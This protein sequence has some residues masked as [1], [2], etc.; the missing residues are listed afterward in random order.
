MSD[1][2]RGRS[3]LVSGGGGGMGRGSALALGRE[4]AKVVVADVNADAAEAV[5]REVTD[6]GGQASALALDVTD[7]S[8]CERAVESTLRTYGGVDILVNFAGISPKS[9]V[10]TGPDDVWHR[11][12]AINLTGTFYLTRA[13]ARPMVERKQGTMILIASDRGLYGSK[14]GSAYAASKAGVIAYMKSLALE[15]GQYQVTV[16]A[17]NPGTTTTPR[18]V[19]GKSPEQLAKQRASDP[20]GVVS[21]PDNIAEIVLFL[22]G[23]GGRFMTGQL[24]TTR[25]RVG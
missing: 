11:T 24:I 14:N 12:L 3:V 25:M 1:S 19:A 20:L 7:A 5:A 22:A 23:P 16:N 17:I 15:L 10:L 9:D 4:G 2:V 21:T 13:A 8:S 6:L 18:Q